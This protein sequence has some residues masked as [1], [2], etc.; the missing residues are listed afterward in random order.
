M[1]RAFGLTLLLVCI[2]LICGCKTMRESQSTTIVHDVRKEKTDSLVKTDTQLV[3]QYSH[4]EHIQVIRDSVGTVPGEEV[5]VAL[6]DVEVKPVTD[7]AGNVQGR[8]FTASKGHIH[9]TVTVNRQGGIKIH[10]RED[11]LRMVVYRYRKDSISVAHTLD[12]I[13]TRNWW[14]IS[15]NVSDSVAM[16]SHDVFRERKQ[17]GIMRLWQTVKN[18]FAI[19]GLAWLIFFLIAFFRKLAV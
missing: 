7:A 19:I 3:R 12:S 13:Q 10:C 15:S 5:F 9:A 16:H 17:S 8:T 1:A 14:S 4:R 6:D 2:L 11:S 18:V